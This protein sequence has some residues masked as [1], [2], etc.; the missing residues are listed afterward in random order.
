M[1]LSQPMNHNGNTSKQS[2]NLIFID[3]GSLKQL[4]EQPLYQ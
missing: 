4:L 2:A 3:N 1:L